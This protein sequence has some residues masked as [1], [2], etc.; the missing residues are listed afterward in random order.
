M[1]SAD[2]LKRSRP[3]VGGHPQA[4]PLRKNPLHVRNVEME[5]ADESY[6]ISR[7]QALVEA[8]LAP[9]LVSPRGS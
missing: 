5:N 4:S 6:L 3:P 1:K 8:G 9:C 7:A 2:I